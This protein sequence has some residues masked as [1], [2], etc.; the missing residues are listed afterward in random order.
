MAL[1]AKP[2]ID[3]KELFRSLSSAFIV[4]GIDDPTFTIIEENEAHASIAM[5]KRDDTVG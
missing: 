5:V 3:Y 1:D 4:F 2:T